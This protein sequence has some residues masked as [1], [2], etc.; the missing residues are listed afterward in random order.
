[1]KVASEATDFLKQ[2]THQLITDKDD[3]IVLHND[4]IRST[5]FYDNDGTLI[6]KQNE[7]PTIKS[8]VTQ[9]QLVKVDTD[10]WETN[11]KT[12]DFV[13]ETVKGDQVSQAEQSDVNII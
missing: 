4:V 5:A 11:V 6:I 2:K 13:S 8:N 10:F 7:V 3:E 9:S 1:M 12:E